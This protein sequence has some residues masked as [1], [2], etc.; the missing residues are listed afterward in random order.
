[1]PKND[2]LKRQEAV[3]K[4]MINR[5]LLCGQQFALDC[6]LIALHRSGWGYDRLK[7]LLEECEVVS[8]CYADAL[9]PCME[10]DV[11]QEQMDAEL[12]D[13]VKGRQEFAPFA[14]RYP[15]IRTAGYDRMPRK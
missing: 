12:R 10:Q 9:R 7:R 14:E 6:M 4:E 5:G 2:Y 13:I 11:R 8:D 3:R 1:M 15:D